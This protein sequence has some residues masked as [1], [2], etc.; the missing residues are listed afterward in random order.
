[1]L[2]ALGHFLRGRVRVWD[3]VR[4]PSTKY[5]ATYLS[6]EYT[7]TRLST[8]YLI[9]VRNIVSISLQTNN[10]A[11]RTYTLLQRIASSYIK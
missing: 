1:M 10:V 11:E 7:K 9:F 4:T 6:Y 8:N 3:R 2:F 5:R